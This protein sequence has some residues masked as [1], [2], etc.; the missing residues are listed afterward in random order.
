MHEDADDKAGCRATGQMEPWPFLH[1]EMP[2]QAP[3]REEICWELNGAAEASAHHRGPDT[4]IQPAHAFSA[5]DLPH[6]VKCIA[7][8][9]L[10]AD[11][12]ERRV[13]LES[14]LD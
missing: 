14:R 6:P 4:T 9:V 7:V 5:V 13:G 3:L 11:G 1:P 8:L 2:R 10:R 12:E